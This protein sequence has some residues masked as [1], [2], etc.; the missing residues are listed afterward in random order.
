MRRAFLLASI[1]TGI[2]AL[3]TTV[4]YAHNARQRTVAVREYKEKLADLAFCKT[5]YEIAASQRHYHHDVVQFNE[6]TKKLKELAKLLDD[7][8]SQANNLPIEPSEVEKVKWE[9]QVE[10]VHI[11]QETEEPEFLDQLEERCQ[12]YIN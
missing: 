5:G 8:I 7:H 10:V 6:M 2:S 12:P 11:A 3:F 9:A 1:A 4:T